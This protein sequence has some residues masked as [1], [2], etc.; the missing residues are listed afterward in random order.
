MD[1]KTVPYGRVF[2]PT[3]EEFA[4]FQE[5]V[6]K[7]EKH[8]DVKREGAARIIPPKGWKP[9]DVPYMKAIEP[10]KVTGPIEQNFHQHSSIPNLKDS[11][12]YL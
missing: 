11:E 5:Y 10:L 8:P 2:R 3:T 6:N 4:N 7:L 12:R 1:V 9:N